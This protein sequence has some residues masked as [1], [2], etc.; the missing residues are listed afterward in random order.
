MSFFSHIDRLIERLFAYFDHVQQ[1]LSMRWRLNTNRRTILVL[2]LIASS[3][4][5]AYVTFLA[6]PDAFPLQELVTIPVGQSVSKVGDTLE[7]AHVVRSATLFRLMETL[8]GHDRD[9]RAGD[10]IF[11][12]PLDVY[13]VARR[14][15]IGAFGL[16]P[17]KIRIP[18]GATVHRVATLFQRELP[19]FNVERFIMQAQPLEGFLFP[20][21]YFFLPNAT[22]DT[23]ISAMRQNFDVHEKRIDAQVR[24]FGKPLRDVV[25]MAS[26]V[27]REAFNTTDRR[28]IAGVLWNRINRHMA[29]QADV[30]VIYATGNYTSAITRA[31]LATTSPYNTYTHSGLPPGPIGSPSLDSLLSTVT[32]IKSK[33]LFYLAGADG[34]THYSVTY[35]EHLMKEVLY[36]G[37]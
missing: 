11:T 21:T 4:T 30:T 6:P 27:E 37:R 16:E 19:H 5:Y 17:L 18:E 14:I 8:L 20:D 25:I 7:K 15:G 34:V 36:L 10:Y 35:A 12:E 28:M 3:A 22:E 32:P 26:I 31:D 1:S 13:H 29:L 9:L 24:A 2:I 33:N 23:V